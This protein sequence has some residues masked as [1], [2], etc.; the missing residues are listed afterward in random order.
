M[1]GIMATELSLY[2]KILDE[3]EVNNSQAVILLIPR[4]PH[5]CLGMRVSVC[6][7]ELKKRN[8]HFHCPLQQFRGFNLQD[9]VQDYLQH[10]RQCI[11]FLFVYGLIKDLQFDFNSPELT[12]IKLERCCMY[13][14]IILFKEA[15]GIAQILYCSP[16]T[17]SDLPL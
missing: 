11:H 6:L 5:M 16:K 10:I 8:C 3:T 9:I 1:W 2:M 15:E 17:I 14:F 12:T 7:H 4:L 13:L